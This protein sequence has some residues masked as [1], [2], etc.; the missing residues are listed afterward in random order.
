MSKLLDAW[1]PSEAAIALIRKNGISDEQIA[2]SLAYLKSKC[3]LNDI[4]EID[5]YDDWNTF[6]IMFCIKANRNASN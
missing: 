6:F 1:A 5:G 3:E 2:Q 4:S